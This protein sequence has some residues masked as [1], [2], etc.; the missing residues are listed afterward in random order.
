MR[1]LGIRSSSR[2]AAKMFTAVLDED[3]GATDARESV[4]PRSSPETAGTSSSTR[5]LLW[6]GTRPHTLA[7]IVGAVNN[8][9][10]HYYSLVAAKKKIRPWRAR[11]AV[12][13]ARGRG[14]PERRRPP[15][16]AGPKSCGESKEEKKIRKKA[17]RCPCSPLSK[18]AVEDTPRRSPTP[19]CRPASPPGWIPRSRAAV[20]VIPR[21][22]ATRGRFL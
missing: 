20:L 15:C 14:G 3:P 13:L 10:F 21:R 18:S 19:R 22:R 17:E 8:T 9:T 5:R 6:G 4:R 12:E 11:A 16:P 2:T 1:M 7:S